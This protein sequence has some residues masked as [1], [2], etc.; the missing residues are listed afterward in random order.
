MQDGAYLLAGSGWR[1]VEP[2][3][4]IVVIKTGWDGAVGVLR[5][6]VFD[7]DTQQPLV[8][9]TV[10]TSDGARSVVTDQNGNYIMS[11]AG[12]LYQVEIRAQGYCE[13]ILSDV[14]IEVHAETV[15]D[16]GLAGLHAAVDVTSINL[17][18]AGTET[19]SSFQLIHNGGPC[20]FE[21]TAL[22]TESWLAVEP[23]AGVVEVGAAQQIEVRTVGWLPNPPVEYHTTLQ[24]RAVALDSLFEIPV[25][26]FVTVSADEPAAVPARAG[27]TSIYPNPFNAQATISF[28]VSAED[29]VTL[30][31][32]DVVGQ[33]V[34]RL[35][36][37]RFAAGDYRREFSGGGLSSGIYMAELTLGDRRE[38]RKLVLLR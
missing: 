29:W 3:P 34:A 31:I 17:I 12:G 1:I 38:L 33:E 30:K 36:E 20:A 4:N 23:E 25:S 35:A 13:L 26:V 28:S 24:V 37:G 18:W 15:R 9:A 21:F 6:Q 11:L 8:G 10:E 2:N 7:E 16:A 22:E 27:F 5:G 19:G 32:Y 14:E